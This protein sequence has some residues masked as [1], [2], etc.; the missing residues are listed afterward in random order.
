MIDR[1]AAMIGTATAGTL[2]TLVVGQ[3]DAS[4]FAGLERFGIAAA[5]IAILLVLYKQERDE[6]LTISKKN[7]ELHVDRLRSHDDA[8]RE[9]T[10]IISTHSE[11]LKSH[12]EVTGRLLRVLEVRLKD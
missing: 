7:D 3:V 2:G 1:V 12:T 4:G 9:L 8:R 11:A 10:G 5:T 6:R